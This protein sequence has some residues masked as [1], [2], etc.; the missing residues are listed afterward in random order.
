MAT[1]VAATLLALGAAAGRATASGAPPPTAPAS[2]F[3]VAGAASEVAEASS[4][5]PVVSP[6][7]TQPAAAAATPPSTSP[8]T[9]PRSQGDSRAEQRRAERRNALEAARKKV[10]KQLLSYTEFWELLTRRR[11]SAVHFSDDRESLV[12]TMKNGT[13][14]RVQLPFDPEL[15]PKLAE[16]GVSTS[17]APINPFLWA[18]RGAA[19]ASTPLIT[20]FGLFWLFRKAM[21]E[22]NDDFMSPKAKQAQQ[23]TGVTLKDVAGLGAVRE[24]AEELVHY[25]RNAERYLSLGAQLPAGVLMVGPPGTGKTLLA[26]AIAG[27]A[28]VPFFYTAGSEFMEMF[29][30]VG[31]ARVRNLWETARKQKPC[32]IFIDEFDAIGTSRSTAGYG[33]GSEESANTINQMLT[34]MDG[35]ENNSGLVILAA[36]NRPQ[37]LD[38][39]LTRPGRFDRWL[40]VPLPDMKG[41]VEIMQVHARGKAVT[42][43]VDWARVA[44]ATAGWSGADLE[45]LMNEAAIATARAEKPL[46]TTEALFQAVDNLRRDP[47]TGNMML[48]IT[49][50]AE[51]DAVQE[52]GPRTRAVITIMAAAKAVLGTCLVGAEELQRVQLFPGGKPEYLVYTL[53]DEDTTPGIDAAHRLKL[54][55]IQCMGPRA[56][57]TLLSRDEAL[58]DTGA[59]SQELVNAGRLARRL[60]LAMGQSKTLGPVSYMDTAA[61]AFLTSDQVTEAALLQRMSPS[62][63]ALAFAECASLVERSE[64]AAAYA[65]ACNLGPLEQ[66]TAA[67]RERR[68]MSGPEIAAFLKEHGLVKLT[69]EEIDGA[70]VDPTGVVAFPPSARPGLQAPPAPV[71]PLK[72]WEIM[73]PDTLLAMGMVD[74]AANVLYGRCCDVLE[75]RAKQQA[76]SEAEQRA[77][78]GA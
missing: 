17:M 68:S 42:P 19:R 32:I 10:N 69:L 37:V 5:G 24:E 40:R 78:T 55:L 30:G 3:T 23:D 33:G 43:D 8:S 73:P 36:T 18:W 54:R 29:V 12:A 38:K 7:V 28:G 63:A 16:L 11:V 6:L 56:G 20:F 49:T 13:K 47:R 1:A 9:P 50:G 66:L 21:E 2:P 67:L 15:L 25:L 71:R 4:L 70:R 39:A 44:R 52:M 34:E 74:E 27:E 45:N 76:A 51:E 26:R 64:A 60:V 58:V 31:A 61:E 65:L 22:P 41:R 75:L 46:I 77:L 59:G 57:L 14:E 53:P 72:A 48:A 35:F 62:V